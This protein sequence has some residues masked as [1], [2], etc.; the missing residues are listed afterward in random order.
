MKIISPYKNKKFSSVFDKFKTLNFLL[1]KR[2]TINI[3]D[4]G[5]NKGQSI[6]EF[7]KYINYKKLNIDCFEPNIIDI[8]E[9]IKLKKE[10]KSKEKNVKLKVQNLAI[11]DVSNKKIVF[12]NNIKRS[13]ISSLYRINKNSKDFIV[14]KKKKY[15][16]FEKKSFVNTVTLNKYIND[17]KINFIDV[18]KI[19]TQGHELKCLRG[20]KN[21]FN[22][23]GIIIVSILFFDF[24]KKKR[25]SFFDIEKII[26]NKFIFWD[27]VHLYKN[28]KSNSIDHIEVVYLNKNLL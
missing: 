14:S 18:L 4:V 16:N 21:S 20:A 1:K 13:E 19:D 27:L 12:Y 2:K 24:Y 8:D 10:F 26:K 3:I 25:I 28:P 15:F 5:A 17:K 11:S 6:R 9:L 7:E 22:K 23:I